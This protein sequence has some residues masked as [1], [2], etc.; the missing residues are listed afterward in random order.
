MEA[1][2]EALS[3]GYRHI[4]TAAA[5]GNERQVGEVGVNA[6]TVPELMEKLPRRRY[7][8]L[9]SLRISA[10][11]PI[12]EIECKDAR[13]IRPGVGFTGGSSDVRPT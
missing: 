8:R 6:D 2:R 4:D 7:G 1:V 12:Q 5:Y 3:A 11:R 10:P 9:P 13:E